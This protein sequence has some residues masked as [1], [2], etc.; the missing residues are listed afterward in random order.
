[1]NWLRGIKA[2]NSKEAMSFM[3]RKL[4]LRLQEMPS[5]TNLLKKRLEEELSMS[6]LKTSEMSCKF[7]NRK[8]ELELLREEN[9]RS[10]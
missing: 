7:K 10:V 9:K 8:K 5:S 2:G 1:M 6:N 4:L 3:L